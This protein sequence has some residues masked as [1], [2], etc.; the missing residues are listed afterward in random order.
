[1]FY[2]HSFSITYGKPFSP[3]D[4]EKISVHAFDNGR[5]WSTESLVFF[6][7]CN[8]SFHLLNVGIQACSSTSTLS[9]YKKVLTIQD[10]RKT[11][12]VRQLKLLR[13]FPSIFHQ[14]KLVMTLWGRLLLL[15]PDKIQYRAQV[16]R[17]KKR[18]F[19]PLASHIFTSV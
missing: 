12:R 10:R 2:C 1:M 13:A 6:A 8:N 14:S 11:Y 16:D 17:R 7:H 18:K 5:Y 9:M 19:S 3:N 4:L 15:Q